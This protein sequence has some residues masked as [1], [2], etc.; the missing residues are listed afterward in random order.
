MTVTLNHKFKEDHLIIHQDHSEEMI[1]SQ[2]QLPW[3]IAPCGEL[4]LELKML[5]KQLD[6][7]LLLDQDSMHMKHSILLI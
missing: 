6:K 7:D 4:I 3:N 1:A 5:L 2:D